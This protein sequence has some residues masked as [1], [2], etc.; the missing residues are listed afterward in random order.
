M[1]VSP[2][3]TNNGAVTAPLSPFELLRVD[4]IDA[5]KDAFHREAVP[6]LLP[7]ISSLDNISWWISQALLFHTTQGCLSGHTAV[8]GGYGEPLVEE[9][10]PYPQG[11]SDALERAT[12]DRVFGSRGLV[13]WPIGGQWM[14]QGNC[15]ALQP[16]AGA[17]EL[18]SD[19]V[20]RSG[21]WMTSKAYL[22]C[23]GALQARFDRF[24]RHG[25]SA[26]PAPTAPAPFGD[27][28]N[29]NIAPAHAVAPSL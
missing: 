23:R 29:V 13:P 7:Y 22:A 20:F 28:N 16:P 6:L 10:S 26:D 25:V 21:D 8:L 17:P 24:M 12:V 5:M 4:C 9:H 19:I 3:H 2:G 18:I 1:Q 14:E 27:G 15:G 11:R